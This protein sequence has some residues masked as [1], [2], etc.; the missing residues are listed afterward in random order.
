MSLD[1]PCFECGNP[2]DVW[3]HVVPKI[4]GG[5]KMVP[6]CNLCHSKVHQA[7]LH[8]TSALVK[9]GTK[10]ASDPGV[11]E[12]V[13]TM[14]REGKTKSYIMRNTGLGRHATDTIIRRITSTPQP[15]TE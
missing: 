5:T 6:L 13:L 11:V 4:L 9:H 14:H 1:V 10:L 8:S 15:A 7:E 2:A 3:H 12:Q